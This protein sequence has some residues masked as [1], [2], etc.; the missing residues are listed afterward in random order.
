MA[1][2]QT[3]WF[4]EDLI[5]TKNMSV[6]FFVLDSNPAPVQRLAVVELGSCHVQAAHHTH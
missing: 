6:E 3:Q 5:F 4:Q 2:H 1:A